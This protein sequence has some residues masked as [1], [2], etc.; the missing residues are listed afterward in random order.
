MRTKVIAGEEAAATI[1]PVDGTT[2]RMFMPDRLRD[3][4]QTQSPVPWNLTDVD[5]QLPAPPTELAG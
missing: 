3:P 4:D 2:F 1:E 5:E